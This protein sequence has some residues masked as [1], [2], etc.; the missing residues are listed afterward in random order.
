[1]TN[2]AQPRVN[3]TCFAAED[4]AQFAKFGSGKS[5]V[6]SKNAGWLRNRYVASH[7]TLVSAKLEAGG[8]CLTP[9]CGGIAP[10]THRYLS[11]E[12]RLASEFI[13]TLP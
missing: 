8:Q 6:R 1:M 4:A 7:V 12:T 10:S 11:L 5:R 13:A 2:A 9:I 3:Q